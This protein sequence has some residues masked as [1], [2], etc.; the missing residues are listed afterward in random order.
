MKPRMNTNFF[1]GLLADRRISQRQLAA[2]M[3]TAVGKPMDPAAMSLLL[4]GRRR[5][6]LD[7]ASQLSRLLGVAMDDVLEHA[8]VR[9]DHAQD[10]AGRVPVVGWM[11]DGGAVH[12]GASRGPRTVDA[13]PA[14]VKGVEA[15][16]LQTTMGL[17]DAVDGG[18]V[19]YRPR[20][21]VPVE[22]V[23]RWCVVSLEDG[24]RVVRLV[25]RGYAKGTYAL[26]GMDGSTDDEARVEAAAPVLWVKVA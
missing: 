10:G 14:D 2:R 11:D 6:T 7:E 15:I 22:A 8:G 9:L 16:R 5:M 23:G 25:K 13:P 20:K 3:K 24:G 26:I 18:F 19:Y 17:L 12:P 21:G 4:R 1:K